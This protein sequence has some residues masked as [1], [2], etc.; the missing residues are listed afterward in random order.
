MKN[1]V[2]MLGVFSVLLVCG[3][4]V[5]GCVSAPQG[6]T[7]FEIFGSSFSQEMD[8]AESVLDEFGNSVKTL[9]DFEGRVGSLSQSD[10]DN[11]ENL[12]PKMPDNKRNTETHIQ[13]AKDVG[14]SVTIEGYYRGSKKRIKGWD[15]VAYANLHVETQLANLDKKYA[16]FLSVFDSIDMN[17]LKRPNKPFSKTAIEN[18]AAAN[19]ELNAAKSDVAAKDFTSGKKDIDRANDALKRALRADPNE[20]QQYQI[21]QIQKELEPVAK[22]VSFGDAINRAGSAVEGVVNRIFGIRK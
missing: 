1:N 12:S 19:I 22:N 9:S 15:A 21:S 13:S 10:Y 16:D 3:M 2:R 18:I 17:L 11:L 20:I 14:Q 6:P 4:M 7:P 8:K 5:M